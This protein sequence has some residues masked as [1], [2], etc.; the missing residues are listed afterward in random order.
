MRDKPPLVTL[1]IPSYNS[2][3]FLKWTLQSFARQSLA[4][5]ECIVVDD[6]STDGSAR[7]FHE[8][9][10]KDP[11]FQLITHKMNCGLAAARNIALRAARGTF[12]AFLDSDDLIMPDSLETRLAT[13]QWAQRQSDRYVGA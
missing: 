5:F 1:G 4:D 8:V 3:V 6:C 12:T 10:G 9:V 11:R 7:Y 13:C 2:D